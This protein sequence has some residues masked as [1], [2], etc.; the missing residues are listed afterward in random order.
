MPASSLGWLDRLPRDTRAP[1]RRPCEA[2]EVF[3]DTWARSGVP[4]ERLLDAYR[5]AQMLRLV[6]TSDV[7]ETA[8]L[9]AGIAPP[10]GRP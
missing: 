8:L 9:L 7:H 1:A 5:R 6:S 10:E 3:A 2:A 4:R